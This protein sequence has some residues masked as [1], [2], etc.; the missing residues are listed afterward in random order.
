MVDLNIITTPV[1]TENYINPDMN[2]TNPSLTKIVRFKDWGNDLLLPETIESYTGSNAPNPSLPQLHYYLYD[3]K[4]NPLVLSKEYGP[5]TSYIWGYYDTEP[6][7]VTKNAT[8]NECGYTG[9]E[10]NESNSFPIPGYAVTQ[11]VD[12]AFSGRKALEVSSEFGPGASFPVGDAAQNHS[13]YKASVWVKG[14][15]DAYIHIQV[16]DPYTINTHMTNPADDNKWHL[17]EV[18]MPRIRIA[19]EF[20]QSLFIKVYIGTTGGP[21]VFDDLRFYPMDA[22][23]TTYTYDPLIGMTSAS[24]VNNKPTYYE[25]DNFGRLYLTRDFLGNILKKYDYHYKE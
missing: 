10:S 2:L 5:H 17:I 3:I 7:A 22:Q 14:S 15:K 4:G 9:F 20:S 8:T 23:M 13:G 19:P 16:N 1:K 18:E 11:Y 21:A 12:D 24:D 25:Y 6:I